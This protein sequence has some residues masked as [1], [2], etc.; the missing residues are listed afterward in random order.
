MVHKNKDRRCVQRARVLETAFSLIMAEV[1]G[2]RNGKPT[3]SKLLPAKDALRVI[4]HIDMDAFYAQI[5]HVSLE[6]AG[7]WKSSLIDF[8]CAYC[9]PRVPG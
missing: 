9:G 5:E 1:D 4:A 3:N 8:T 6:R 2:P 7:N